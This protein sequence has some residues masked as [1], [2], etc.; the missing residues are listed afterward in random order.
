MKLMSIS[1]VSYT[2][3]IGHLN[4]KEG[5][6]DLYRAL[7]SIDIAAAVR[8]VLL[9]TEAMENRGRKVMLQ[10][11]NNLAPMSPGIE[12][13][14]EMCIRDRRQGDSPYHPRHRLRAGR[15]TAAHDLYRQWL[16]V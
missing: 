6:K 13:E 5:T 16:S 12:F 4:K 8:S 7:G 11:K 10:L 9:V 15:S 1:A 3:L 14:L 2:H